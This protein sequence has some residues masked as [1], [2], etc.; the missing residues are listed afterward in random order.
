MTIANNMT[1]LPILTSRS[2]YKDHLYCPRMRYFGWEWGKGWPLAADETPHVGGVQSITSLDPVLGAAVHAGVSHLMRWGRDHGPGSS[3]TIIDQVTIPETVI[4]DAVDLGMLEY[5]QSVAKGVRPRKTT[6]EEV[7]W[8][9]LEGRAMAEGMIRAAAYRLIPNLL[10][11]YEVLEVEKEDAIQI[12]EV[13]IWGPAEVE[14]GM[15]DPSVTTIVGTRPLIFQ[16]KLDALLLERETGDLHIT[17]FKTTKEWGQMQDMQ[18]RRDLQGITESLIPDRRIAKLVEEGKWPHEAT[19]IA[20]VGMFAFIKG[21][22]YESDL[23]PGRWVYSSPLT[24]AYCM[25]VPGITPEFDTTEWAFSR[26]YP[27]PENKSGYGL[28]G[29]DWK[30]TPTWEY[31]GGVKAWIKDL[32]AGKIRG[33][34]D[35][36]DSMFVVPEPWPRSD[37]DAQDLLEQIAHTEQQIAEWAGEAQGLEMAGKWNDWRRFMNQHFPRAG[38]RDGCVAYGARCQFEQVC[39]GMGRLELEDL[40]REELGLKLREPHHAVI[41]GV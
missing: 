34:G 16:A 29:K 39:F 24:S 10:S 38:M 35:P 17:S 2:A 8:K 13:P 28:L 14:P 6:P 23:V 30:E 9:I 12:G 25:H 27:K 1:V 33:W 3:P 20:M 18:F 22:E 5:D 32:A 31:P 4:D 36:F 15:F 7:G 41:E 11:R 21:R 26:K 40:Y 37:R 19:R